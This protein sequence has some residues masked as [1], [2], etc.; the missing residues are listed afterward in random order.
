MNEYQ[1][2][3]YVR[4]VEDVTIIVTTALVRESDKTI[5]EHQQHEKRRRIIPEAEMD[6]KWK[7]GM[8]TYHEERDY[9]HQNWR[10]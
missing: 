5:Q 10:K 1:G 6:A 4:R 9:R 2:A 7:N 3:E 8:D